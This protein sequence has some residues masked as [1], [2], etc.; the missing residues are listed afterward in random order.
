MLLLTS[1]HGFASQK[2][3]V[4][5]VT[6]TIDH[7]YVF[8]AFLNLGRFREKE[9]KSAAKEDALN[10]HDSSNHNTILRA[11]III[12]SFLHG[13]QKTSTFVHI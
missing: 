2:P 9:L 11:V 3:P 7:M 10:Q 6:D 4:I 1:R 12:L 5:T 13:L 8:I